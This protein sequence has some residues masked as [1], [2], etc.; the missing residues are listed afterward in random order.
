MSLSSRFLCIFERVCNIKND[1]CFF[2]W[3]SALHVQNVY[4]TDN[5]KNQLYLLLLMIWRKN[6][7]IRN[8]CRL[9]LN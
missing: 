1:A 7:H 8:L 9:I 4:S 6:I 5:S 2:P 3:D